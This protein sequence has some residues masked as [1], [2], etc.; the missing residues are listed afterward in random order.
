MAP[1]ISVTIVGG[2]IGGL[3]LANMFEKANIEYVVLEK[4]RGVKALGSSLGLDAS[5]LT[6][7]EQLGLLQDF[8][9]ASKPVRQFNFYNEALEA[10]GVVDFACMNE[11][12]GYPAMIL[13]RPAFYDVLLKN[14]PKE[15]ILYGK[16]VLSIEQDSTSATV[17]CADGT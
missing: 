16:R 6:V 9:N 13:D 1:K 2:G 11:I 5:S 4:A 8:Y 10:T 15:K 14:L 3:S 17:K 7:M 12:G